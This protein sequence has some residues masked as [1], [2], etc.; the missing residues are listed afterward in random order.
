MLE[1]QEYRHYMRWPRAWV[2]RSLQ[3]LRLKV[4]MS[5]WHRVLL[6]QGQE[7]SSLRIL[8]G[9]AMIQSR[10]KGLEQ[11]QQGRFLRNWTEGRGLPEYCC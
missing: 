8:L 3:T 10:R 7:M 1:H 9:Q 6:Q 5:L 11:M 2:E 4:W